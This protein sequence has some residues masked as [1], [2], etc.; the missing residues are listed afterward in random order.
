MKK[1]ATKTV[2]NLSVEKIMELLV[3]GKEREEERRNEPPVSP[4]GKCGICK[5]LVTGEY[6]HGI[7]PGV[8]HRFVPIGP[9]G[10]Q[11]Y[12]WQFKGYHCTSCGV[13][14]KFPP[15]EIV[16]DQGNVDEDRQSSRTGARRG[17][18]SVGRSGNGNKKSA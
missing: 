18:T 17:R 15:K 14:Y 11:Y 6:E 12:S 2:N 16:I 10:N 4:T 9:G 13:C 8:D 7:S 5:G 3:E 1:K